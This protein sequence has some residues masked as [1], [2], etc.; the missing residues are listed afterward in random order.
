MCQEEKTGN[1]LWFHR[2]SRGGGV[3]CEVKLMQQNNN[4]IE[5]HPN[6]LLAL[7]DEE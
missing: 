4:D 6:R 3:V 7:S 1:V 2:L 5:Q